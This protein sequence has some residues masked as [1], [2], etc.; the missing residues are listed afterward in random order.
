MDSTRAQRRHASAGKGTATG[1]PGMGRP[2]HKSGTMRTTLRESA[3]VSIGM[4]S[5]RCCAAITVMTAA[6]QACAWVKPTA[7][8]AEVRVASAAEVAA[9]SEAGSTQVSVLDKVAGVRRG[10]GA[11]SEELATLARN[12][13]AQLGGDT[14]VPSSEI[15]DGTQTFA[16]YNCGHHK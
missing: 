10:Y 15:V 6:L 16:V 5:L 11:V 3:G 8:G 4:A 1:L 9:C 14:V 13:A 12:S 2:V 7:S